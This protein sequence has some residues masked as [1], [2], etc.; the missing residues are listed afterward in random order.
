MGSKNS[1]ARDCPVRLFYPILRRMKLSLPACALIVAAGLL[2]AVSCFRREL[3]P[4][5]ASAKASPQQGRPT[6]TPYTGDLSIFETPGREQRLQI[7][8]VMDL[9]K[10]SRGKSVADLGAGSGW[11]TVRVATRVGPNGVVYAE[12]INSGAVRYIDERAAKAHLGNIR[13]V[14]GSPTDPRLPH[15]SVDAVMMLKMYHEIA[16]PTVVLHHLRTALRPGALI[17]VIDKNGN[18]SGTDHGLPEETL[19]RE[20]SAEGFV[21][22]ARYD[23]VKADDED[24]FLIFRE[25]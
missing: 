25:K 14:L 22:V 6:S 13:T 11:F 24:Y 2:A 21:E 18:G 17:G 8:R 12:D 19:V 9:L 10:I 20:M 5:Q 4:V 23:F 1:G 15:N 16:R 3:A 7:D